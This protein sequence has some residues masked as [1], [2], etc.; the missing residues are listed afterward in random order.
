MRWLALVDKE[1]REG[2]RAGWAN[3][4]ATAIAAVLL[5]AATKTQSGLV[6]YLPL[7]VMP[8]HA[9]TVLS[10]SIQTERLRGGLLPLAIYGGR[11]S[12]VWLAK[13]AGAF[14]LAYGTTFLALIIQ[15]I[16]TGAPTL[17]SLPH[18]LLTMPLASL[19]LIGLQGLL[20][21]IVAR[22]SILTT[23][24]PLTLLFGSAQLI[25]RFATAPP[26]LGAAFTIVTLSCTCLALQTLIVDRYPR[27]RAV[28][29]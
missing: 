23:V 5:L 8:F 7:V 29:A 20:L 2:I 21:W 26:S 12:E 22:S 24:L 28:A 10:R 14:V 18:L 25:A 9:G 15:S 1:L 19:A 17:V 27:E 6:L 3:I 16:W 11:M 13:V 4:P